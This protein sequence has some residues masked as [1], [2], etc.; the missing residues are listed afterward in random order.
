MKEE[1]PK[2]EI[3]P[4]GYVVHV[5]RK[6]RLPGHFTDERQARIGVEKYKNKIKEA[7]KA[8]RNKKKEQ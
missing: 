7:A 6:V 8:N 5:T 3:T 4:K 2:F 1:Y